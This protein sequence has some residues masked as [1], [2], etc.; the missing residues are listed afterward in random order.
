VI[1]FITELTL[2]DSKMKRVH[3]REELENQN[4]EKKIHIVTDIKMMMK[5]VML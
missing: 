4:L 1:Q 2:C 5:V 3:N